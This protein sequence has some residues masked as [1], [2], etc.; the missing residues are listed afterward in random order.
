M[1]NTV[2]REE[3]GGEGIHVRDC[4]VWTE[5]AYL[6]SPSDFREYLPRDRQGKPKDDP[7]VMLDSPKQSFRSARDLFCGSLIRDT[8]AGLAVVAITILTIGFFYM[9]V[10]L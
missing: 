4:Y 2:P 8:L 7:L 1:A 5:I 10:D 9:L 3:I 6:D